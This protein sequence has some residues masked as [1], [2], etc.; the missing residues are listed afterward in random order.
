L[1]WKT[2][3]NKKIM[4]GHRRRRLGYNFLKFI[5]IRNHG[6]MRVAGSVYN[7]LRPANLDYGCAKLRFRRCA[8]SA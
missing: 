4:M 8:F 3:C 2:R 5:L 7:S 6:L 1:V